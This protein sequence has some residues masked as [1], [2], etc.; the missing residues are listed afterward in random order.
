MTPRPNVVTRFL[1]WWLPR[2]AERPTRGR[3]L[4]RFSPVFTYSFMHPE[5]A[6]GIEP[7]YARSLWVSPAYYVKEIWQAPISL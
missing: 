2:L 4:L 1:G 7:L 5:T 6:F 3:R